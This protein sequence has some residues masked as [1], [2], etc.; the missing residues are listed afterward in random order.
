[1]NAPSI[2]RYGN[3]I[4]P[5]PNN[6]PEIATPVI[7][8]SKYEKAMVNPT[9]TPATV[10]DMTVITSDARRW[11]IAALVGPGLTYTFRTYIRYG[12]WANEYSDYLSVFDF[13][14]DNFVSCRVPGDCVAEIRHD[15]QERSLDG[16]EA[17]DREVG[18]ERVRVRCQRQAER[19]V[20]EG[21]EDDIAVGKR[22]DDSCSTYHG[23]YTLGDPLSAPV[24]QS[25]PL[26]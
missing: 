2:D 10:P 16:N 13:Y 7:C 8:R 1:M 12:C 23:D 6:P 14:F 21:L 3:T 4:P 24:V 22:K 17:V 5:A 19:R 20:E 9:T 11:N 15:R 26:V 18:K 25:R